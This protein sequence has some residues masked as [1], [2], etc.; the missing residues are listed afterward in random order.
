MVVFIIFESHK[1]TLFFTDLKQ[2]KIKAIE[3]KNY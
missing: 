1:I 2:F 3:R